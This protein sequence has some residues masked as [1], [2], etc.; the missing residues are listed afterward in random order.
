MPFPII[1]VT[2]NNSTL[3]QRKIKFVSINSQLF[4]LAAC[5]PF[6]MENLFRLG[7][8]LLTSVGAWL[9]GKPAAIVPIASFRPFPS[10]FGLMIIADAVPIAIVTIRAIPSYCGIGRSNIT[11]I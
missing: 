4:W 2:T 3:L 6:H 10:L 1:Y 11:E 7:G 9:N 5:K 8:F